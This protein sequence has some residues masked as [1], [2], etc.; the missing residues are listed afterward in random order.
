MDEVKT[1]MLA[2]SVTSFNYTVTNDRIRCTAAVNFKIIPFNDH[3]DLVT[4]KFMGF[5]LTD[6][7][8][9]LNTTSHTASDF[10]D[11]SFT[12]GYHI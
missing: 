7:L 9:I 4:K 8:Y 12:T 6:T 3:R 11:L 2:A 1:R 10:Y 5:R